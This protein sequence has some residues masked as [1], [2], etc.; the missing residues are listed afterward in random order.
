MKSLACILLIAC[1]C[2]VAY[3]QEGADR[4]TQS[5]LIALERIGKLQ[6]CQNKDIKTLDSILDEDFVHVDEQGAVMTKAQLLSF[7]QSADT[8]I[9]LTDAMIVKLHGDT[10]IVTGL[11]QLKGAARG[12]PFTKQGRFVDTWIRKG[13]GW[14]AIASLSTPPV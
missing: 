4:A 9:F 11:F 3:S 14:V 1:T 8:L 7:V 12:K 6:A 13:N 5:K 10:A 2:L